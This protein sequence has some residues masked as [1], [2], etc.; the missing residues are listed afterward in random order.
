MIKLDYLNS[1]RIYTSFFWG[2]MALI[3]ILLIGTLGYHY[4]GGPQYSWMDCFYMTFITI[5]TIGYGEIVDLSKSDYGRLFTVFI[6]F[7]GIATL[8]YLL[9]SVTAFILE[10]DINLAWRRS[11]MQKS[12]TKLNG[13][14]IMCGVGR[15]GSNVAHELLLTGRTWCW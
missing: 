2:G 3:T 12:I 7:S 1:T 11:K 8:S 6:G 13:H 15:V 4:L 10:G 9:S 14:Y 5:A